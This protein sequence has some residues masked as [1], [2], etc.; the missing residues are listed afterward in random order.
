MNQL[1]SQGCVEVTISDL[2]IGAVFK[3]GCG[4]WL[5]VA[6]VCQEPSDPRR[7][8]D[9]GIPVLVDYLCRQHDSR[10]VYDQRGGWAKCFGPWTRVSIRDPLATS[11]GE[12]FE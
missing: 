11:L 9:Y 7:T 4:C 1:L 5:R 2:P 3:V 6:G 10:G 12:S 8:E